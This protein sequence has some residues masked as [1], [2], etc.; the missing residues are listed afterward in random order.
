MA[1]SDEKFQF[2]FASALSNSFLSFIED[3]ISHC[4]N[5]NVCEFTISDFTDFE[6]YY[7]FKSSYELATHSQRV[8]LFPPAESGIES[9]LNNMCPKLSDMN[10]VTFNNFHRYLILKDAEKLASQFTIEEIASQYIAYIKKLISQT[11]S[12]NISRN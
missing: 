4:A 10:L 1:I 3:I 8:F 7:E 9:Y 6:V 11:K 5:K 12:R 2:Y